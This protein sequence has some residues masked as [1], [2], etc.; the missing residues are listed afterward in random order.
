M[1]QAQELGTQA[2]SAPTPHDGNKGLGLGSERGS[3]PGL[4]ESSGNPDSCFWGGVWSGRSAARSQERKPERPCGHPGWLGLERLQAI[5]PRPCLAASWQML[6]HRPSALPSHFCAATGTGVFLFFSTFVLVEGIPTGWLGQALLMWPS[7]QPGVPRGGAITCKG[8]GA[9][10]EQTLL[11]TSGPR[12][13]RGLLN[14]AWPGFCC[15]APPTVTPGHCLS[16]LSAPS[17]HLLV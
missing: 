14:V 11:L 16:L 9:Y 1:A 7:A 17:A 8:K 12:K 6:P 15:H 5:P 10:W 2:S 4:Q 13:P 3:Q